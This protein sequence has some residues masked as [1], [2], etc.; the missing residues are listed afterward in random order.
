MTT[1]QT[2]TKILFLVSTFAFGCASTGQLAARTAEPAPQRGSVIAKGPA[3]RAV[4]VGPA[5]IRAYSQDAGGALFAA[6]AVSGTDGDC[7]AATGARASIPRDRVIDF[8]VGAGQVAC[9]AGHGER[10]FELLWRS[11][12]RPVRLAS[13]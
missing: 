6:P 9:V 7:R 8:Q 11:S 2:A 5:A 13:R 3:A 10:D 12:P 4:L 1:M